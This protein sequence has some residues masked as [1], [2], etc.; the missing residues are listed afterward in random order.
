MKR[1]E[2][3]SQGTCRYKT[4]FCRTM[5]TLS[6]TGLVRG[7]K[8]EHRQHLPWQTKP[9]S[10]TTRWIL[11]TWQEWLT[12]VTQISQ[13]HSTAHS[14]RQ[15]PS[16]WRTS[17]L[18]A[19]SILIEV[20]RRVLEELTERITFLSRVR[21]RQQVEVEGK[22]SRW[23]LQTSESMAL[24]KIWLIIKTQ[25]QADNRVL[26]SIS[27]MIIIADHALKSRGLAL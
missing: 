16:R 17:V 8:P 3:I 5:K 9:T 2:S 11:S 6:L 4:V 24:T 22:G 7:K 18:K 14:I 21:C 23:N 1:I 20:A 27:K 26:T 10:R 13:W 15:S 12:K 19:R 25:R